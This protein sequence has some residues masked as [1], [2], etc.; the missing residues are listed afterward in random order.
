MKNFIYL[1]SPYTDPSVEIMH[2]RFTTML[3]LCSDIAL[4]RIPHYSPIVH[5]HPV[6]ER[7]DMP[8]DVEFWWD[9]NVP[10]MLGCAAAWFIRLPGWDKSLGMRREEKYLREAHKPI[11]FMSVEALYE[12]LS[13]HRAATGARAG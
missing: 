3:S 1:A 4:A 7:Y 9:H 13:T 10:F 8:R 11:L 12:H 2:E 5:W 6:A